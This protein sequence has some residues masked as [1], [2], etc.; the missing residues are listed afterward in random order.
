MSRASLIN[1]W[2]S[3]FAANASIALDDKNRAVLFSTW[4]D[5][6]A[7]V[8]AGRLQAAFVACLRSH[9]FKTIPTIGDVRKHLSRAEGNAA[10]EEA[11]N[12]WETVRGYAVRRSPDFSDKNPPRILPR[13]QAAINAAGGLDRIRE[14][15]SDALV[16]CRKAFLESYVRWGELEQDQYLL[17]DGQVKN[18][19]AQAAKKLLPEARP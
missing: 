4:K 8:D 3:R 16:W 14:C 11:A 12:K 13:T 9:T 5:G 17:P 15:D 1:D 10:E 7:D 2:L 18:L 19:L 6:F